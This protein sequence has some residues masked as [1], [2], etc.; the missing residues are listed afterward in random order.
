MEY[1]L[2][3]LKN[4]LDALN[5][6]TCAINDE[7][8]KIDEY[9]RKKEIDNYK[10]IEETTL[11]IEELQNQLGSDISLT[12]E[13]EVNLRNILITIEDILCKI[14]NDESTIILMYGIPIPQVEPYS[15][16][17]NLTIDYTP[18][19]HII[20]KTKCSAVENIVRETLSQYDG[21]YEQFSEK[22]NKFNTSLIRKWTKSRHGET[23]IK[24]N[25]KK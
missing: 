15:I 1:T 17:I 22:E 21:L 4:R 12:Q 25:H 14:E 11:K 2:S 9:I 8:K 23:D 6:E 5:N 16:N 3:K 18:A 20:I 19:F 24:F 10:S 7:K 13:K